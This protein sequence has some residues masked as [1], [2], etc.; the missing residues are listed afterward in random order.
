[1]KWVP[2]DPK[3]GSTQLID[4]M[5]FFFGINQTSILFNKENTEVEQSGSE[6]LLV[7]S[8]R[9]TSHCRDSSV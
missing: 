8:E 7:S 9:E 4:K 6:H 3:I 1:M 2:R 5:T